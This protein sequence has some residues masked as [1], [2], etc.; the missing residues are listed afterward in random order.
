[1]SNSDTFSKNG[2][3]AFIY[4]CFTHCA[5]QDDSFYTN[6]VL[7]DGTSQLTMQAATDKW[8]NGVQLNPATSTNPASNF[9]PALWNLDASNPNESCSTA[10]KSSKGC[11]DGIDC[12]LPFELENK[13]IK[14]M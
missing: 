11:I 7:S 2:N 13:G 5:A 8:W 10:M 1:M 6:V 9:Y 3:G 14:I 12:Y 4:E